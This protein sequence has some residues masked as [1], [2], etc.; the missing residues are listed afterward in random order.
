MIY[1]GSRLKDKLFLFYIRKIPGHPFKLRIINLL[2]DF[3]FKNAVRVKGSNGKLLQ[4]STREYMCHEIIFSGSY[5]PLTLSLCDDLLKNGGVCID[6]GANIGFHSIHLSFIENLKIYAIEPYFLSFQKLLSNI[7]LNKAKNIIPVNIGLSD[8]DSFGYLVNPSPANSGTFQV[9]D[10]S[11]DDLSYLIRLGTLSEIVKHYN[12][13]SIDLM[14]IDVEG[15]EMNVFKGFF[16]Q[17]LVKPKNIIMEFSDLTER[18]GYKKEEV[19]NY[20][21]DQ[22]YEAY[23]VLGDKFRLG[24][25]YP[26]ANLWFRRND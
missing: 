11:N 19:Y 17:N 24:D 9:V 14:K 20:I 3:V 1:T 13:P 7:Y 5:E 10:N 23:N 15:F 12:L 2:N 4:L 6:I 21:I 16:G 26:E 25:D 8:K 18:T 22:G